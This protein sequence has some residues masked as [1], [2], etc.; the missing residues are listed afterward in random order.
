M[1][2]PGEMVFFDRR[3]YN[4]AGIEAVFGFCTPQEHQLFYEQVNDVE[5]MLVDDGIMLFKFYLDIDKATQARRIRDRENNPL[6]SWKLSKLDYASHE[7]YDTYVELREKMFALSGSVHAPWVRLDAVDKKRARLNAIRFLL[8]NI[9]YDG[10]RMEEVM[11]VDRT[12]VRL[13]ASPTV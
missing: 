7:R 13:Y 4:R 12:I 8:S 3:C 6:K 10:R 1:P 5:R 2:N 9:P 11:G